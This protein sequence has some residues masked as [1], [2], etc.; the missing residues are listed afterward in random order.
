MIDLLWAI[1]LKNSKSGKLGIFVVR[2]EY[3]KLKLNLL[4]KTQRAIKSAF[5]KNYLPPR[6]EILN[7]SLWGG[8]VEVGGKKI[9]FQ[10]YWAF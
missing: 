6:I 4:L 3:R 1:L 9:V 10:Q 8:N 7:S 2:V 5:S